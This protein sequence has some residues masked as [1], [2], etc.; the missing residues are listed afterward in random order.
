MKRILTALSIAYSF[1]LFAE[2]GNLWWIFDL[3][4]HWRIHYVFAGLLLLIPILYTRAQKLL[5]IVGITVA[6]HLI[7]LA[8]YLQPINSTVA[9]NLEEKT[10]V[11]VAYANTYWMQ[12]DMSGVIAAVNEMN[13]DVV[14]LEEIQ[15]DQYED[16]K[17]ALQQYPFTHHESVSYAFDM[18]VF[19]RLPVQELKTHYYI[20]NVPTLE[21]TIPVRDTTVHIF[22]AHPYSPVSGSFT[23]KRDLLLEKLFEY[24]DAQQDT[25]IMGGDFNITQF[26][27]R[28][29]DITWKSRLVDTQRLFPLENTWPTH[30]PPALAIPIDQVFVSPDIQ[31]L[32]R[33]RGPKTG[34]DHWPLVVKVAL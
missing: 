2:L 31:V 17:K 26:S 6:V 33:Y 19:S 5:A 9:A 34:S 15:P 8:P 13:A 10:V 22:G 23:K 21:L 3:L 7:V 14:F 25:T 29:R 27:P 11:T 16:V 28:F 30:V 12:P 20:P 32:E 4:S 1:S 18:A 24:V